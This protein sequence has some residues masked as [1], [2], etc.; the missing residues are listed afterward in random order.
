M[1]CLP[2]SIIDMVVLY[3]VP[4]HFK[5]VGHNKEYQI[6]YENHNS[7]AVCRNKL[8]NE[9]NAYSTVHFFPSHQREID[10]PEVRTLF[11]TNRIEANRIYYLKK[12]GWREREGDGPHQMGSA[13]SPVD[14]LRPRPRDR[15]S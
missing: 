7:I 2:V 3:T 4:T 5:F 12:E 11:G 6:R 10:G 15:G 14:Q 1:L 9:G 8:V 13:R